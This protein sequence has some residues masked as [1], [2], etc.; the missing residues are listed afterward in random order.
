[1]SKEEFA[2]F[3]MT[4]KTFYPKENLLPSKEAMELWYRML[5][6]I[7]A[8][9]A[10]VFLQKWVA[11]SKWP[12]TIAEI[13]AGCSSLVKEE[14]QD[15]GQ[16]WAEVTK[17]IARYGYMQEQRALES[18]SPIT[19]QTVERLGWKN[20]CASENIAADRANFRN[21]YEIL[22]QREAE[23]R[24]LPAALK[25][26]ISQLQIGAGP[27]SQGKGMPTPRGTPKTTRIW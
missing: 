14:I 3:A 26:T 24:Q 4:L 8:N 25:E 20:L 23:A 16:G 1:M 15:W 6:D 21:C 27:S 12:P 13:R 19:R 17:A 7:Q 11:T 2:V 9:I 18:M 22:S 5:Q 10:N